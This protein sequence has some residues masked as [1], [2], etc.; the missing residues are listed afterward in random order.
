MLA[1][2]MAAD[3]YLRD[4]DALQGSLSM[5]H[6]N[7]ELRQ[8]TDGSREPYRAVLKE[9]RERLRRTRDW[10]EGGNPTPP[11][12]PN[13]DLF[14]R[15][16]SP[17]TARAVPPLV[18]RMQDGADRRRSAARHA[19]ARGRLR[20]HARPPRRAPEFRPPHRRARRNHAVPRHPSRR[21][22]LRR[23]V[24][25]TAPT[26]S[27]GGTRRAA[28]AVSG[29]VARLGRQPRSPR[30]LRGDRIAARRRRRAVRDFHGDVAERR[31]RGH[32]AA[33]F[34]RRDPRHPGRAAVRNARRPRRRGRQRSTH[35]STS[36]GIAAT[37][38]AN[39]T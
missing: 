38:A 23:M 37:Q 27:V 12:D 19:A 4:V 28:S 36:R 11:A 16:R 26:V 2:W 29:G 18:A 33:A 14:R 35:C 30:D 5:T 17:R 1:R 32:P 6:A 13:T 9:V 22:Q 7:E 21:S 34:G 25:G 8:R 3:L 31:A 15:R 10:A 39:N 24:R 20:H